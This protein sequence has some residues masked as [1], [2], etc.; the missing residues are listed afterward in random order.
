MS[1]IKI[2]SSYEVKKFDN[3]PLFNDSERRKFFAISEV[4]KD[5]L[6][7]LSANDSKIRFVLQLGY[8]RATG[9]L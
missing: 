4:V 1:R 7:N 9:K 5:K 6:N 2:L 8:F 3:V